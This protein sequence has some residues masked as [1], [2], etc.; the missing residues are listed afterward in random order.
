MTSTTDQVNNIKRTAV[1]PLR[2]MQFLDE[3]I[4][5]AINRPLHLPGIVGFSGHSGFGKSTAAAYV[6]ARHQADYIEMRSFWKQKA[7]LSELVLLMRQ[8]PERTIYAMMK[9][10]VN[11]MVNSGRPLIIDEFDHG[12]DNG[13]VEIV[14]DIYEQTG[15]T[16]LLIGEEKMPRKLKQWERFDG[17]IY[18]WLQAEPADMEDARMLNQHYHNKTRIKDDLLSVLTSRSHGS[19][20][21][22]VVNIERIGYFAR[23]EGL[24][25]IGLAEW[26]NRP[27]YTGT[28]VKL[29]EFQA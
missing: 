10:V 4:I 21:R 8:S 14:R 16:I 24:R 13:Q 26:G 25:E 18:D 1:A 28:D 17:R 5:R 23:G 11:A 29:R 6:A 3:L 22:L 9:Q 12:I 27:L 2:N 7:F 20:R 15:S 19:V